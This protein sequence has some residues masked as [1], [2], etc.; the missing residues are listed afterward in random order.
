[1]DLSKDTRDRIFAAADAL[2]EQGV[3]SPSRPSMRCARR[4]G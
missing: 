4:R 3:E 2:Y 1:M